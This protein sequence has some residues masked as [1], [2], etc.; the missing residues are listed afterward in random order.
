M[1]ILEALALELAVALLLELIR[2]TRISFNPLSLYTQIWI[3]GILIDSHGLHLEI[4]E[5]QP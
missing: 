1:E 4:C 5:W 2:N 3:L